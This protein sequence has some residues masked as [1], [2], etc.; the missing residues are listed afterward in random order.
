MSLA[1]RTVLEDCRQAAA[2]FAPGIQG[3]QWR[4]VY[5]ANLALLRAVYH[6]LKNRDA[7]AS[8]KL[9]RAFK[10]WDDGLLASRPHPEIY[11][12][13]I[14]SERN[15]LLKEYQSSAGQGATAPGVLTE[16]NARTG[17][18]SVTRLGVVEHHYTM[19]DGYFAGR[20]QRDLIAEAIAW[21]ETQLASLEASAGAA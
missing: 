17:E 21:W 13:F 2:Q 20:D 7:A 4:I 18:Q 16:V 5:M 11:W 3:A 15:M 12:E 19:N 6:V 8:T 14:V 10:A 1:A 9:R